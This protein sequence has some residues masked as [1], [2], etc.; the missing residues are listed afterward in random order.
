[1]LRKKKSFI[2]VLK[3][4]ILYGVTVWLMVMLTLSSKKTL[5]AA[6]DALIIC[7]KNII[8]SLFP[9]FVLSQILIKS[10]FATVCGKVLSPLMRKLFKV[11]GA[12]GVAFLIGI[13]SGYPMGAKTV[14]DL[15]EDG[16][17]GKNE[18]ERLIPYCNNSG[19]LFIIGAVGTGM[20]GSPEIGIFL[21]VIHI[22]SALVTGFV[23]RF[24]EK[25]E[26]QAVVKMRRSVT[27]CGSLGEIFSQSVKDAVSSI[28]YV[29]G[30]V[31]FFAVLTAPMFSDGI[32]TVAESILM[33]ILE[34]TSGAQSIIRNC[35]MESALPI[36]SG[37]I[38]MGGICVALQVMGIVKASGL[39]MKNYIFGKIQHGI[40]SFFICTV[41]LKRMSFVS[42]FKPQNVINFETGNFGATVTSVFVIC[43][44]Y[45]FVLA[46]RKNFKKD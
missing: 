42:T 8:P 43:A 16:S 38:G 45:F 19:P 9:F 20:M 15:Y 23:L 26:K 31:V 6:N 30:F 3:R 28:L 35:N 18:A 11:S 36:I 44:F 27:V 7:A 25:D 46:L 41:L 22:F 2:L 1:M 4:N 10:G 21:Y 37:L 13:I 5:P 14:C 39:S 40:L 24:F 17:L 29:C 32:K 34:V 33:G 12:G